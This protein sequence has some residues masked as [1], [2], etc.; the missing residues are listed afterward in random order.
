MS[1]FLNPLEL[2]IKRH[3]VDSSHV[4]VL[5]TLVKISFENI[6]S[7]KCFYV[8]E[9]TRYCDVKLD[10]PYKY[11]RIKYSTKLCSSY[12]YT[13]TF[14]RTDVY[15]LIWIWFEFMALLDNAWEYTCMKTYFFFKWLNKGHDYVPAN[16]FAPR[17]ILKLAYLFGVNGGKSNE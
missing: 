3:Y 1:I 14:V 13:A 5:G 6:P 11:K 4:N 17:N 7:N 9:L 12:F 2:R 16:E 15:P 8:P 10:I